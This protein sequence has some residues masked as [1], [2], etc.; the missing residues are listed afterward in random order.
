MDYSPPGSS[1][2]GPEIFQARILD[3]AVRAGQKNSQE[4]VGPGVPPRSSQSPGDGEQADLRPRP[5][6]RTHLQ[7]W[8]LGRP[9]GQGQ[10]GLSGR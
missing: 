2:L 8:E 9:L 1:V 6:P 4:E 3:Q 10:G 7:A 5:S